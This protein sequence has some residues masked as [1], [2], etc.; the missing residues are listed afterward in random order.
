MAETL[1]LD[2][3]RI[4]RLI[5]GYDPFAT[6]G[7]CWF[8]AEAAQTACDFFPECLTHV[9]GELAGKPFVLAPRQQAI[10]A[11]LFGWKRPDNTRRYREAFIFMPRKTG[12][13]LLTAGIINYVLF[14]DGE[15]GAEIYS[16][17]AER[18]QARLV[19]E[20]VKAQIEAEPELLSRA[21][22]YKYSIVL[23]NSSYKAISADAHTKHGF[24]THL[25]V[26][27]EL[28]AQPN[29]E[30]VDV[31]ST[32]TGARRQ[33]LLISITTSDFER[34]SIC[35]E[36]HEYASKVRDGIID[37]PAFLPVIYEASRDDDW[38]SPET[39]RK[40]IPN[41]NV[42]VSEEFIAAECRKAQE[43][44]AFENTFKRLY[45][46]IRTEQ[47]VRL[48]PMD[49]WD[50]CG[51]KF[52]A[53]MLEGR[54]CYAGL[55][56]STVNDI[57]ACVLVFAPKGDGEPYY[58][59]PYIWCPRITAEKRNRK[60]RV[61]YLQWA[62]EGHIELTPGN[63][64][65]YRFIRKRINELGKR[66]KIQEVPYDPWNASHLATEL[67]E[68]DGF[69]MVE[70]RQGMISMNEPTKFLLRLL[71]DGKLRH[72]GNPVLRWMASNASG[73]TDPAGNIK[74]DKQ[75]SGEKID[76]IVALIMGLGRTMIGWTKPQ[77]IYNNPDKELVLI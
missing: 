62:K 59:L 56:L 31:L 13:S 10:I 64:V 27:D 28:H 14:C 61:P 70:F 42:S 18:D 58:V 25:A 73:K 51:E 45:L 7:D 8:D 65:D 26:I 47:A 33:P 5:P 35:N 77:S 72:G 29:R 23:G 67:G 57:T 41:L 49:K 38:T 74:P 21:E 30:L 36:K 44:P 6:A 12:K 53:K 2:L 40:A 17:A 22:V 60:S 3:H 24:N 52:D 39:W 71:L 15:P 20:M 1:S 69:Q 55:D 37:D 9:K 48:I 16:A 63:S 4:A 68:E 54:P 46:N 66:F 34:E 11:N 32:S 50:A 19:F 75:S 76:G 43:E